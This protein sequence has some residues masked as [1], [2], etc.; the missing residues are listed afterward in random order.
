AGDKAALYVDGVT[1]L[2]TTIAGT[3][4]TLTLHADGSYTYELDNTL[5]AT[6]AL[7]PSNPGTETFSYTVKDREGA[8]STN[9]PTITVNGT[10]DQPV[11]TSAPAAAL[12]TV[13]EQGT[14]NPLQTNTVSGTLTASDVDTGDT[15]TWS[16]AE[17]QGLYG[18]IAINADG[19][20]TYTLDN[21]LPATI[22]L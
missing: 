17:T 14:A 15:K 7:S 9:T 6:Q 3:Y 13:T 12:G 1:N 16:I 11:I 10:N 18:S 22:A 19:T 21:N 2:G 4:G 20:W 8:T 5:A